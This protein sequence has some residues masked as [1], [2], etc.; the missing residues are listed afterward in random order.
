M[1]E[2]YRRQQTVNRSSGASKFRC[3]NKQCS[4]YGRNV[5]E[6]DCDGCPTPAQ[7]KKKGPCVPPPV[8]H[9][10]TAELRNISDDEVKEMMRAAGLD[11]S[12]FQESPE[13]PAMT[14]QLWLYKE[15]LIRWHKAGRPVRSQEQV[16]KIHSEFCANPDTPCDYYDPKKRRCKDCGCRVTT[17][18]IAVV[19][20]IKM[21]TESCPKGKW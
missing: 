4:L 16:Q 6:D 9:V 7:R 18:A 10:S 20:K 1:I 21:A 12:E 3:L 2:C 17:G 8:P 11:E 14:L 15:A 5:T 19:N 13:Y